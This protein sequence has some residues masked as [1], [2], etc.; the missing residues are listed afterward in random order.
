[1]SSSSTIDETARRALLGEFVV[2]ALEH[3]DDADEALATPD[4]A[5][6][7]ARARQRL[8]RALHTIK[9]SASYL[10]LDEVRALAHA[11]E[12]ATLVLGGGIAVPLTLL[13]DGVAALRRL[14]DAA[15]HGVAVA[16]EEIA[17]LLNAL[18]GAAATGRPTR[19]G[20][21][22]D[23]FAELAS[24]QCLAMR[25]AHE[26][27]G[28]PA[29]RE[30]A[31]D[32]IERAWGT[33]HAA[34]ERAAAAPVLAA[35]EDVRWR[36]ALDDAAVLPSL[37]DHVAAAVAS[38][39]VAD[40]DGATPAAEGGEVTP[41]ADAGTP[42]D[43][44][45]AATRTLRVP[46]ARLDALV[47]A[48]GELVTLRNQLRHFVGGL[49]AAGCAPKTVRRA[50]ALALA[51]ARRVDEVR[52]VSMDLR[53]VKL[54]GLFR[55][56]ARVVLDTTQRT[57][58]RARLE[59]SGGDVQL[60]KGIAETIADPMLHLLR[61]AV[62]HGIETPAE[63][64]ARGKPAEGLIRV[65]AQRRGEQVLVV[66][67][68]DGGGVDL[69][70]VRRTAVARGLVSDEEAAAL[71]PD[72][73]LDLLFAPGFSTAER[74]TDI[75]G[76]G[77]GLDVVR[78]SVARFGGG[79]RMLSDR[80]GTRVELSLPVRMAAR[81]VLLVRAGQDT[82]AIP[83]DL[84]QEITTVTSDRVTRGAGRLLTTLRGRVLPLTRLEALIGA[85]NG[86][87]PRSDA[88]DTIVIEAGGVPVGLVVDAVLQHQQVVVKPLARWLAPRGV[89]GAAVLGDGSVVLV[90]EPEVAL[91]VSSGAEV[92]PIVPLSETR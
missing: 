86:V 67:A 59:T 22:R 65:S 62:D 29:H 41:R 52:S 26:R 1:M 83:L 14:V 53:L 48:V 17:P 18:A 12:S 10:A 2:E 45:D 46:Q 63:R 4:L 25:V 49:D 8:L 38:C 64:A 50:K 44:D 87:G 74:V 56:L 92:K 90:L 80:R 39:A 61:N 28:E 82:V 78:T 11:L 70:R 15:P 13:L 54:D 73:V 27:L 55:R 31:I 75:S 9:G 66:I 34:A 77:V 6:T 24:Q 85:S 76:R 68:D 30:R 84:V 91:G 47:E 42:R 71:E 3:L 89:S 35:L 51:L 19:A 7:G 36:S 16:D 37:I 72:G 79:V 60:D 21:P 69:E 88:L 43:V 33:L 81:D 20:G 58:K 23:P 5:A 32:A 40:D 57:G